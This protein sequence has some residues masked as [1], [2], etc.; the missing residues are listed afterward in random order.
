MAGGN[1]RVVELDFDQIKD[2][3][4]NFLRN[5]DYFTDFDFEGSAMSIMLDLLA[6]DTHYKAYLA[7]MAINERFIDT[8]VKRAS[9]ISHAKQ[10]GYVPRSAKSAM[11]LVNITVYGVRLDYTMSI[12]KYTPF[13][14]TI[15]DKTYT[16]VTTKA[17]TTTPSG[18]YNA[19]TFNNVELYEGVPIAYEYTAAGYQ[20]EHFKIPAFMVDTSTLIVNVQTS[21]TDT[22]T[23]TYKYADSVSLLTPN[24]EV[25]FIEEG[26][27][28]RYF[29]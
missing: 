24:D 1:L 4:K 28:E 12:D 25:Y 17:Y 16:F 18:E 20:S 19:Y 21:E 22:T 9:V 7:N 14:A 26:V 29:G 6:Y 27:D 23:K 2:N 10:L 11:A 5:Q 15:G 13:S 3:L 8:S